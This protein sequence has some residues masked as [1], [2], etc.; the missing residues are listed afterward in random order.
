PIQ[1]STRCDCSNC[2]YDEN[3]SYFDKRG[4]YKVRRLKF[5]YCQFELYNQQTVD[6]R[7]KLSLLN[8]NFYLDLRY[9]S[10]DEIVNIINDFVK[11]SGVSVDNS[12][13]GHLFRGVK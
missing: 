7:N 1:V 4:E 8:S 10:Q 5:K 3:F 9:C 11:K 12:T 2:K 13:Y 6:V